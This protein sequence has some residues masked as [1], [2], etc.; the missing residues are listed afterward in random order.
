MKTSVTLI[1]AAINTERII[2]VEVRVH[3]YFS[4]NLVYLQTVQ[5]CHCDVMSPSPSSSSSSSM[6][7]LLMMMMM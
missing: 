2:Y 1:A 3:K 7:L 6:L 5:F 4:V